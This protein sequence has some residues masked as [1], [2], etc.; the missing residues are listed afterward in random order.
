MHKLESFALSCNSKIDKPHVESLFY[1]IIEDNFICISSTANFDS[2]KYNYFDDVV[3]HINPYLQ[4]NNIKILQ[5]GN[6]QDKPLFYCNHYLSTH[7]LHNS[8]ILEKSLMYLGNFNLYANVAS[9]LGKKIVC[10]SNVDYLES[11]FPYWS[12]EDNCD[13]IMN[14]KGDLKPSSSAVE[15]PKTINDV[16]PET[17][18]ASVLDLLGI[19]H[20]LN[21]IETVFIG[22]SYENQVVEIIPTLSFNPDIDISGNVNVR[23]DKSFVPESL[24]SI[25]KNRKLNIVTD[26]VID[27]G[28]LNSI[29]DS[30]DSISF[31]I[32][33]STSKEDVESFVQTGQKVNL[34]TKDEKS[35]K[36]IRLNFLDR[37]IKLF[38]PR[39]KSDA[40]IKKI[41]KD[42]N[43]LSKKNVIHDNQVYN[44]F[45]SYS[46]K[47]NTS[48]VTNDKSLWED[49]DSLRIFKEKT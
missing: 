13:I 40:G 38:K 43:F 3:F 33:K 5:I 23:L 29:K 32:K 28:I 9:S 37:D 41:T 2:K 19:K 34:F 17:I 10:P 39:G 49:L 6:S 30:I 25:A 11:F 24:L 47:Q 26:R 22:S 46:K 20:D 12:N 35:L 21:K 15:S 7:R 48:K 8:Y 14:N 36:E 42:L 1:P 45:L 18:A 31:F 27:Q 44:S 16:M 4:E